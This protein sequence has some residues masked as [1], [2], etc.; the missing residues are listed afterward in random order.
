MEP[1]LTGYLSIVN[2]RLKQDWLR[3]KKW[4]KSLTPEYQKHLKT[5]L[6]HV[7]YSDKCDYMNTRHY[8]PV[9]QAISLAGWKMYKWAVNCPV[10]SCPLTTKPFT[11]RTGFNHLDTGIY[12]VTV[13]TRFEC[14][15]S[16]KEVYTVSDLRRAYLSW[17]SKI[18][19]RIL[20][21]KIF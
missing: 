20:L 18:S 13:V 14:R 21:L 11:N 6:C 10:F 5:R 19:T 16:F 1:N 8:S 15:L 9:F 3:L 7:K 2:S 17:E 4:S 12:I